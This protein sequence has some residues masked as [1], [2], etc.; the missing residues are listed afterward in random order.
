[1]CA[2]FPEVDRLM[3]GRGLLV[4][5]GLVEKRK[6]REKERIQ[7]RFG[8]STKRCW[9]ATRGSFR[10]EKDVLFKMKELVSYLIRNFDGTKEVQK[11]IRRAQNLT[12][13]RSCVRQLMGKT[14]LWRRNRIFPSDG[15]GK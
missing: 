12:E 13:Y 10:G 6:D 1:M 7:R 15:Q 3:L 2:R 11:R 5:P 9:R 8:L 14:A 4:D